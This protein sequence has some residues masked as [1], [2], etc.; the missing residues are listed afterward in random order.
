MKYCKE[1]GHLWIHGF[2]K[3]FICGITWDP[4]I[5]TADKLNQKIK[6]FEQKYD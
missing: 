4:L 5:Y 2:P 1:F 3:C 6:R